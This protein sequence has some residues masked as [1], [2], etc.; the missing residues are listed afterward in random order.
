MREG[1]NVVSE[2]GRPYLHIFERLIMPVSLDLL[3]LMTDVAALRH[4]AAIISELEE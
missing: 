2:A 4:T 3:D 1:A